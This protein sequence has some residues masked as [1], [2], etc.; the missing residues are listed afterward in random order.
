[1]AEGRILRLHSANAAPF[2]SGCSQHGQREKR[3]LHPLAVEHIP[4]IWADPTPTD[5]D[6]FFAAMDRYEGRRVLVHCAANYRASAFIMLY[7]VLRL[8]WRIK[9]ALPD[10]YAIWDPAEYPVWQALLERMLHGSADHS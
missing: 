4:V 3:N 9:D 2:R 5:L 1:M 10:M 6:A 7:R 8:G